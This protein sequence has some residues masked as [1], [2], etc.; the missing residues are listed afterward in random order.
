MEQI[1]KQILQILLDYYVGDRKLDIM[2]S[3]GKYQI[4]IH[5]SVYTHIVDKE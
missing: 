2:V 5:D 3:K 1:I 4:I